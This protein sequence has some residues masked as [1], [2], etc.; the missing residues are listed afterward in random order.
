MNRLKVLFLSGG[1]FFYFG[2]KIE[3]HIELKQDTPL[4]Q[5]IYIY[6]L[7]PNLSYFCERTNNLHQILLL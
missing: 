6:N 7:S 1:V 4:E 3:D 2:I 5:E